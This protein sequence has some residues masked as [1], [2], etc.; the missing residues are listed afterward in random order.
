MRYWAVKLTAAAAAARAHR[1]AAAV[2]GH[3]AERSF[4]GPAPAGRPLAAVP[5]SR[6]PGADD[7]AGLVS[8]SGTPRAMGWPPEVRAARGEM[9]GA[10]LLPPK[11][12]FF[13]SGKGDWYMSGAGKSASGMSG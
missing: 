8:A 7:A 6:T 3:A 13:A 9:P 12:P 2:R 1:P 10:R 4:P 5:A 11:N